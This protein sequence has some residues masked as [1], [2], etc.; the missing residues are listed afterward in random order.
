MSPIEAL[1]VFTKRFDVFESAVVSRVDK[2]DE[3]ADEHDKTLTVLQKEMELT[4]KS[5][6]RFTNA[7]LVGSVSV[8]GAAIAV[9]FFGGGPVG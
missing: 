2:L 9:I 3:R 8:V 1:S 5:L 4:R 6:D 7:I